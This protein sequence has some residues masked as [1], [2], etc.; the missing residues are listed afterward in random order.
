MRVRALDDQAVVESGWPRS[1]LASVGFLAEQL[2]PVPRGNTADRIRVG[3]HERLLCEVKGGSCWLPL[4]GAYRPTTVLEISQQLSFKP[5]QADGPSRRTT[6]CPC[7]RALGEPPAQRA[8]P[9]NHREL[10]VH[11]AMQSGCHFR[12]IRT[13]PSPIRSTH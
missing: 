3:I 5:A 12:G 9:D 11:L 10:G 1:L 7:P 8:L 4:T 13:S 2:A 6:G